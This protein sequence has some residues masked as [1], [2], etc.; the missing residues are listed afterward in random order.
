MSDDVTSIT[1]EEADEL[2]SNTEWDRVESLSDEEIHDAVEED[3]DAFLLDDDWFENAMLVSPSSEKE[4]ISIRLDKDIL[5]FFRAE[6]RGYQS[7]I[8]KVLRE[9]MAVQRYKKEKGE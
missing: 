4:R 8:N 5:A 1:L 2:E 7:R 9:Y 6:G 3:P